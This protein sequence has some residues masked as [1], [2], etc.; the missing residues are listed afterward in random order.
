MHVDLPLPTSVRLSL[1]KTVYGVYILKTQYFG[2]V[3][4]VT[5]DF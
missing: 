2:L 5:V 3:Y 4:K 1:D